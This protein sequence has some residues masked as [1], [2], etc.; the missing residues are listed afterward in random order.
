MKEKVLLGGS[1]FMGDFCAPSLVKSLN[2]W[3]HSSVSGRK[4]KRKKEEY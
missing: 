1:Q 2:L 3:L 4:G